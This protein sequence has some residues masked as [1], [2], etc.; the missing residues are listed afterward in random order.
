MSFY[1]KIDFTTLNG[2]HTLIYGE[3]NTGK[4]FYTAKFIKFLLEKK[5]ISANNISVLDFAPKLAYINNMKIGGRI[6][7]YYSNC[8]NCNL[9]PIEGEILPPRLNARNKKELYDILCH[10]HKKVTKVLDIFNDS[11]TKILV[12]NDLSIYLHLGSK[13]S[14]MDVIG[15]TDTFFGN[16]YYGSSINS[17]FS[18]LLSIKEK[19]RVEFLIKNIENSFKTN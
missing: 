19:I 9:I 16:A 18:K 13:I 6:Q 1:D 17:D 11:P 12:I 10:N 2:Y 3:T 4:T 5:K 8:K 15:K 7:D 14:L